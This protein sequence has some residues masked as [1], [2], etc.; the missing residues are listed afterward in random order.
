M[1]YIQPNGYIELMKGVPLT[2]DY[3][4]TLFF[5][6]EYAQNLYFTNKVYKT[7]SNQYYTRVSNGIC[8]LQ[9]EA[10]DLKDCNYMRFYNNMPK[11]WTKCYYAFITNVEYINHS[12]VEISFEIDE[13]QTWF[14]QMVRNP[15]FVE[16]NHSI[17]DVTGDNLQPEPLACNEYVN[18][19]V[20][21]LNLGE[22]CYLIG[23]SFITYTDS[24]DSSLL[25]Y[26]TQTNVT[27]SYCGV[28]WTAFACD[29]AG[30]SAMQSFINAWANLQAMS[31][32][33]DVCDIQYLYLVPRNLFIP[34]SADLSGGHAYILTSHSNTMLASLARPNSFID[35]ISNGSPYEPRNKKLLTH[36]YIYYNVDGV[37]DSKDFKFENNDYGGAGGLVPAGSAVVETYGCVSDKPYA[38]IVTM[39]YDGET[40]CPDNTIVVDNFPGIPISINNKYGSIFRSSL[41]TLVDTAKNFVKFTFGEIPITHE[42]RKSVDK[43]V[44][45]YAP[46]KTGKPGKRLGH[47]SQS[48]YEMK[49]WTDV[50][51]IEKESLHIPDFTLESSNSF[52]SN[53][54]TQIFPFM[55]KPIVAS[56]GDFEQPRWNVRLRAK[57]IRYEFAKKFDSY[58]D[59]Y[60]YAINEVKMP[61]IRTR[62]RWTFVKTS[63]CMITGNI[64]TS[65]RSVIENAFDRGITFWAD[66][67]NV[68]NY[69]R[70]NP[71]VSGN[72]G[73]GQAGGMIVG[74]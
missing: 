11:Q 26:L 68:G 44:I 63:G 23:I 7:F 59:K 64:P 17:S 12:V 56:G 45:N 39:H 33:F 20:K 2:P 38:T 16:R 41:N 30:E 49:R 29:S 69:N 32:L 73:A 36:P 42:T 52:P 74:G 21:E 53:S 22:Y 60:G 28:K 58:L 6:S 35:E 43:G 51:A 40:A 34:P 72:V 70:L 3:E 47:Y 46:T 8:R 61:E 27:G 1:A 48:D 57:Q 18:N 19:N 37:S 71:T 14:F 62:L 55:A 65:A 66:T 13:I 31:R 25:P 67:A 9:G 54:A 24:P 50:P 4:H 5:E 15:C 10:E